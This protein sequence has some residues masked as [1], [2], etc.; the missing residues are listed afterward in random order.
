MIVNHNLSAIFANRQVR[1]VSRELDKNME[2][3]ASGES[4][5]KA[6]DDASGLAVSEKMRTQI[7][8]LFQASKNVQNGLS[9]IQVAEGGL[10]QIGSI[11]QRIRVLAVQSAN[12]IYSHADRQQIQVEVS[13]L[14]DEVDRISNSAEFNR[15]KILTGEYSRSSVKASIYFHVGANKDQR[16]RAFIATMSARA[17]KLVN[18]TGVKTSISTVQKANSMIEIVDS[19]LDRLNRQR[20]DLGAY[21]NRMEN[22]VKSLDINHENMLAADSR[23][24]DVDMASEMVEFTKNQIL[25]QSGTAM[26]AQASFQPKQVLKLLG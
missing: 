13:Q 26:M 4:I 23:I 7:S 14:I 3:L 6:G 1:N 19:A 22:T 25:I 16:I 18:Q 20:A 10:Q 15:M 12:G 9:F 21:Y 24:R 8:G 11:L 2:R 17:L 5:N